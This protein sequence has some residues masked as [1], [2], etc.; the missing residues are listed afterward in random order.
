MAAPS[1]CFLS[2]S[3]AHSVSERIREPGGRAGEMAQRLQPHLPAEDLVS[4]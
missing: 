2:D 3:E 4:S 1:W